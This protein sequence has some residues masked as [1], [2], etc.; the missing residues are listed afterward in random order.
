MPA[1]FQA[2]PHISDGKV[3][4]TIINPGT[5]TQ[6]SNT[7]H[8]GDIVGVLAGM[9]NFPCTYAEGAFDGLGVLAV[10]KEVLPTSLPKDIFLELVVATRTGFPFVLCA[11]ATCVT[12][13]FGVVQ[14]LRASGRCLMALGRC[15]GR[16]CCCRKAA[17]SA[18]EPG[19][20]L[21]EIREPLLG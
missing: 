7:L 21:P 1:D 9:E 18:R 5:L 15:I 17:T 12:A 14:A 11:I 8:C 16:K 13:L 19:G 10:P 2:V 4:L 6:Y 20:T 3:P